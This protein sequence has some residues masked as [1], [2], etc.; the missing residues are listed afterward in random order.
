MQ[1]WEY[2]TFT[3]KD[4]NKGQSMLQ[5]MG[6]QEWELVSVVNNTGTYA[7]LIYILKRPQK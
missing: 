6:K 1:K 5:K 7:G 3:E 4:H 2:Y